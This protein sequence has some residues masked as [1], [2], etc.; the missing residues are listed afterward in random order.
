MENVK[1]EN[2]I[3]NKVDTKVSKNNGIDLGLLNIAAEEKVKEE[4]VKAD[5]TMKIN[6][7]RM[8]DDLLGCQLQSV[9]YDVDGNEVKQTFAVNSK[10]VIKTEMIEKFMGKTI[11]VLDVNRY[12]GTVKDFNNVAVEDTCS[13]GT[14]IENIKIVADLDNENGIEV[15]EYVI[16][17]L[18]AVANINKKDKPTGKVILNSMNQEGTSINTFSCVFDNKEL[19]GHKLLR[20]QFDTLLNKKIRINNLLSRRS[21]GEKI[22]YT[23]TMFELA[24]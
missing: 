4:F 23:Y 20:G 18:K 15:N 17:E 10:E 1:N 11:Q 9:S 24:K 22:Y 6:G 3:E 16:V 2:K 14:D 12:P 19:E 8:N 13:Y 7:Y 5:I 21:K